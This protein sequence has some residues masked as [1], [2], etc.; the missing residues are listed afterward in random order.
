MS[1]GTTCSIYVSAVDIP[2]YGVPSILY[3]ADGGGIHELNEHIRV[4]S[5][6]KGRDYL[7]R[8]IQMY[9]FM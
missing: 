7:Y 8:L 9:G 4:S 5:L 6:Y 1:T 2:F 3:E